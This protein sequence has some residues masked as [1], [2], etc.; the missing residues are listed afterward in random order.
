MAEART[1]LGQLR[2]LIQT[3]GITPPVILWPGAGQPIAERG[4]VVRSTDCGPKKVEAT[5]K[6][7][8]ESA[9]AAARR[10]ARDQARAAAAETCRGG[11]EENKSCNYLETEGVITGPEERRNPDNE[12]ERQFRYQYTT[13]GT[14]QCE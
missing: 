12:H 8:W 10:S 3:V 13:R 4:A 7:E 9:R 5:E 6:G 2:D 14:C 1:D 11:C